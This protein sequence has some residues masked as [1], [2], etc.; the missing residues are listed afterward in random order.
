MAR[1]ADRA[2]GNGYGLDEALE[3]RRVFGICPSMT[4]LGFLF[5][6]VLGSIATPPGANIVLAL[7]GLLLL[8]RSR[9]LAGLVLFVAVGSL[10]AF[11][12][13]IVAGALERSLYEHAALSPD[14]EPLA[15]EAIVVLGGGGYRDPL[16]LDGLATAGGPTLE[17]LRHAASLHRR[18][19]LPLLVTGG[20]TVPGMPREAELMTRSLRNDFGLGVR[21]VED[22]SRNTA[23]N[24][25]LSAALLE[26]AGIA[27][28]VL[29]THAAHMA[30]A[31]EAF[32]RQGLA[33]TPA[34]VV[35][36]DAPLGVAAF[37]PRV[38]ALS[39]SASAVHEH[40]GRLWYR[41]RY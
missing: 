41:W 25:A 9:R 21:F 33:V 32:V 40:V 17:R 28:I 15:A 10:Y 7:L 20:S 11:S 6:K 23:E 37:M 36:V 18:T 29:V 16:D 39:S 5:A 31:T 22:R 14:T 2:A 27:R 13:V 8:A 3:N 38:D 4:S 26:E 12:T 24:A 30:R 34:P 1:L 19:G 35:A